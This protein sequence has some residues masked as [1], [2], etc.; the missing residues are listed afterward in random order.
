MGRKRKADNPSLIFVC[1]ANICRS[2][3][4]EALMAVIAREHDPAW[5]AWHIGSAGVRALNGMPA[6]QDAIET[7][8]SRG[9]D[10]TAHRSRSVTRGDVQVYKVII[11]MEERQKRILQQQFPEIQERIFTLG[12]IAESDQ[13]VIDPFGG[14]LQD[15]EMTARLLEKWLEAAYVRIHYLA[16]GGSRHYLHR[17]KK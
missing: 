4:A 3:M 9:I 12:E 6:S 11:T 5:R 13:D 2:P 14:T 15:Y 1:T 17:V 16:N 8:R 7:M 10:I